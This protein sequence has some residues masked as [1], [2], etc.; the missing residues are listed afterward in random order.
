VQYSKGT[1]EK[2]KE[3]QRIIDVLMGDDVAPRKDFITSNALEVVN[4]D[5]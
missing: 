4:L 1:K 3:D 5:I 2:S